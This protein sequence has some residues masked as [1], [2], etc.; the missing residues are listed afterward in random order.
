MHQFGVQLS[1]CQAI[2]FLKNEGSAGKPGMVLLPILHL[3]N[4]QF[5]VQLKA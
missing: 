2:L 1:H 5:I 3:K 4:D